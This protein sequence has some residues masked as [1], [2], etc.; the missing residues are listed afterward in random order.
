MS[1]ILNLPPNSHDGIY[2][3][4]LHKDGGIQ[5]ILENGKKLEIE[6]DE[7]HLCSAVLQSE[8]TYEFKNATNKEILTK[9]FQDSSCIFEQGKSNFNDFIICR[10]VVLD[11]KKRNLTGTAKEIINILQSEKSCNVTEDAKEEFKKEKGGSVSDKGIKKNDLEFKVTEQELPYKG[12]PNAKWVKVTYTGKG[13]ETLMQGVAID[14]Y[15]S[16]EKAIESAKEKIKSILKKE[17]EKQELQDLI[18]LFKEAVKENPKDQESKDLLELY[19]ENLK[20]F[21]TKFE[22]GGLINRKLTYLGEVGGDKIGQKSS[23]EKAKS[24]EK[25]GISNEEIRQETGWFLNPHDKKWRFEISDED[26]EI[27]HDFDKLKSYVVK[28][29]KKGLILKMSYFIKHDKLFEAYP[30]FK[31]LLFCL[32][33]DEEKNISAATTTTKREK[34][35]A[36]IYYN[37]YN[38]KQRIREYLSIRLQSNGGSFDSEGGV[39]ESSP[40]RTKNEG[41]GFG[42]GE[43]E[44]E[45]STRIN[46]FRKNILIH[47]LQHLIQIREGFGG[48][49][50]DESER[51]RLLIEK[52]L[53]WGELNDVQKVVLDLEAKKYYLNSSG[54]IE[55]RDVD[56][57]M[58]LNDEERKN[59]QP[60]SSVEVDSNYITSIPEEPIF[61]N[62]GEL[63]AEEAIVNAPCINKKF[64]FV[65]SSDYNEYRKGGSVNVMSKSEL[66]EFY[67]TKEGKELDRQ[68]HYKWKKLVNMSKSE[69]E[70]FYNSEEGKEAGLSASEAK[71]K[72]IDSGRE[73]ARWIL[74]MKDIPY[75]EWTSDMWRWA[76]KQISFISR[77]SGMKGDLY[78]EKG[79]KTRKHTALLIWGH[80]PEKY[81][82][83]G[84]IKGN[85]EAFDK[86]INKMIS[87]GTN[88]DGKKNQIAVTAEFI[89]DFDLENDVL[90]K[91]KYVDLSYWV[92]KAIPT[93]VDTYRAFTDSLYAREKAFEIGAAASKNFM[94]SFHCPDV[95]KFIPNWIKKAKKELKLQSPYLTKDT[96]EYAN[97]YLLRVEAFVPVAL[98]FEQIKSKIGLRK[99]LTE[100]EKAQKERQKIQDDIY[101]SMPVINKESLS[102]LVLD[103]QEAVKPLEIEIYNREVKRYKGLCEEY[104]VKTEKITAKELER[105]IPFFS[106][107]FNYKSTPAYEKTKK[108]YNEWVDYIT[109][110]SLKPNWGSVV[111]DEVKSYVETLK[112]KLIASVIKNF[113]RV[114]S[115]IKEIKQQYLT[116]GVSGFEGS[117]LVEFKNGGSFIFKTEAIGAGGYNIQVFHFRYISNFTDV[118]MPDGSKGNWYDLVSD[119]EFEN[120]GEIKSTETKPI[121]FEA[122][123]KLT[124]IEKKEVYKNLN[125]SY[126]VNNRPVTE[127][128]DRIV[129]LGNAS[130]YMTKSD[131]TGRLL[132]WYIYLPDGRIAHPTEVFGD[133][134]TMSEID[135]VQKNIESN[136]F[137]AKRE[138]DQVFES[139]QK[140]DEVSKVVNAIH[141]AI[142]YGAKFKEEYDS[143]DIGKKHKR[144]RLLFENGNNLNVPEYV[145]NTKG[146][147]LG[148]E[149]S[150][151]VKHKIGEVRNKFLNFQ[152][153]EID[154]EKFYNENIQFV[155]SD[156]KMENGGEVEDFDFMSLFNEES[157]E[158]KDSREKQYKITEEQEKE[159][160]YHKSRFSKTWASTFKE[161]VEKTVKSY[162]D[163]KATYED[164]GSRE[165]KSNKGVVY[166]GGDD[167]HGSIYT[168][169]GINENRRQ[170]TMAGAKMQMDEAV[171]DLKELGLNKDEISDLIGGNKFVNGGKVLVNKVSVYQTNFSGLSFSDL[172]GYFESN[173][174]DVI[175]LED[176]KLILKDAPI[177]LFFK[178]PYDTRYS[179]KISIDD[180]I[181][182]VIP[183]K[184]E[185]DARNIFDKR[186]IS[187][188]TYSDDANNEDKMEAIKKLAD[189]NEDIILN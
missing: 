152:L 14:L 62:G 96:I 113:D 155:N 22:G 37:L 51:K 78:D 41:A 3:G 130:D 102:K 59:I 115:P 34:N 94:Y 84:E 176:E 24:L 109:N 68:T 92:K 23:L 74:K 1:N 101:N 28:N 30:E 177:F 60:L 131:I 172:G 175:D 168:I 42:I 163:A 67:N 124:E 107:A 73:S 46:S 21:D 6:K 79:N 137:W 185:K 69:L 144:V 147:Y 150:D 86:A 180:V 106:S 16:K 188:T 158:E 116:V 31:D 171:D 61:E 132:R 184:M 127:E 162:F 103:I 186:F 2:K 120:G 136:E 189:I 157:T 167:I 52:Q 164:W 65:E 122:G 26:F 161:A 154:W 12:N 108:G 32:I 179:S 71:E 139:L 134:V 38:E 13:G 148:I 10:L 66:K 64:K 89:R 45:I 105:I 181:G 72:G 166:A 11:D 151:W 138:Y 104:S 29:E 80:D 49:S 128:N 76:K 54:E 111:E 20:E 178:N 81:E 82:D 99:E 125:D 8:K 7:F 135:R 48:G 95:P 112:W 110:I 98:K 119:D 9:L 33:I 36:F 44:G 63:N 174:T 50:S 40:I 19:E 85:S 183:K 47:E 87:D 18:D 27:V 153:S 97:A 53:N 146:S 165:Y 156:D 77:M 140:Q 182:A 133:S 91:A 70:K 143:S 25:Q 123:K 141:T 118:K 83:G 159:E 100:E 114:S 169:G 187:Y 43:S 58:N 4:F 149:K 39:H 90:I 142:T 173:F 117:Y 17:S 160:W 170:R 121:R 56:N 126:K 5:S 57:R 88:P 129:W 75:A 93:M 145:I 15:G 55:A 35:I